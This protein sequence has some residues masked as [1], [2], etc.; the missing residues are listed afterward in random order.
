MAI[1]KS[2]CRSRSCLTTTPSVLRQLETIGAA[3]YASSTTRFSEPPSEWLVQAAVLPEENFRQDGVGL[4]LQSSKLG[5]CQTNMSVHFKI[6]I[7][8]LK[9][10]TYT[11]ELG[12][13]TRS[14]L[15]I[16]QI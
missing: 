1:R 12:M 10:M 11:P 15:C 6:A 3:P 5:I 4:F 16:L 13:A 9:D 8:H 2:A 7:K 14:F